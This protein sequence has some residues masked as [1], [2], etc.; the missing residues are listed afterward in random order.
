MCVCV[1]DC[2]VRGSRKEDSSR[3][4]PK[5]KAR[6][7][8]SP[9]NGPSPRASARNASPAFSSGQELVDVAG[10]E[11]TVLLAS[12]GVNTIEQLAELSP[13]LVPVLASMGLPSEYDIAV[14]INKAKEALA[15]PTADSDGDE[16]DE[17]S[18]SAESSEEDEA[19]PVRFIK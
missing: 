10:P 3:P 5:P 9:T 1:G 16:S 19:V 7:S 12:Q 6:A 8:A 2:S 15:G 14:A 4:R 17:E 18:E 13:D 11:I